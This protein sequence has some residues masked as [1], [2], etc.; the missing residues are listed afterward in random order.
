[1]LLWGYGNI[2]MLLDNYAAQIIFEILSLG[3]SPIGSI[4]RFDGQGVS[5]AQPLFIYQMVS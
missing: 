3:L 2:I 1:M 5:E 4:Y